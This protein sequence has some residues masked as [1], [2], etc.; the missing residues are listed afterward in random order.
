DLVPGVAGERNLDLCSGCR[1]GQLLVGK[2]RHEL[3]LQHHQV[4]VV[5]PHQAHRILVGEERIDGCAECGVEG[6]AAI[7]VGGR[8]AHEHVRRH[9][10]CSLGWFDPLTGYLQKT[11][12]LVNSKYADSACDHLKRT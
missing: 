8:I 1:V 9:D 10:G 3:A 5:V 11:S 7:E 4:N 12:T 6:L 2:G